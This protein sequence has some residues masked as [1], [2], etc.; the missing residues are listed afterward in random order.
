MIKSAPTGFF[1]QPS[2]LADR[3]TDAFKLIEEQNYPVVTKIE[4]SLFD[5]CFGCGYFRDS[6]FFEE[7]PAAEP[8]STVKREMP[9]GLPGIEQLN[10]LY[11]EFMRR[12]SGSIR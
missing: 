3:F 6:H 5:C 9:S 8:V 2:P 4:P 12:G 1:D 10:W 7:R 11:N